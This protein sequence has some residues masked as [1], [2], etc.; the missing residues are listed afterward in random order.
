MLQAISTVGFPI[1]C[2]IA[3]ALFVKYLTDKHREEMSERN[4]QYHEEVVQINEQHRNEM[5][6][7]TQAINNNTLALQVLTDHLNEWRKDKNE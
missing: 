3:M 1:V 4:K 6:E 5:T 7:V 2:V